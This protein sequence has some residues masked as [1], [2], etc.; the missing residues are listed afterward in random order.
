MLYM[1]VE[2][3]FLVPTYLLGIKEMLQQLCSDSYYV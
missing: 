3:S 1:L 2:M